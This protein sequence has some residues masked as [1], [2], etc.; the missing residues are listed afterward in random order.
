MKLKKNNKAYLKTTNNK[1][2][3]LYRFAQ[4]GI[5]CMGCVNRHRRGHYY[6]LTTEDKEH[7]KFPSWKL[8]SKNRKQWMKKPLKYSKNKYNWRSYVNISW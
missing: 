2:Y 8:V 7:R 4:L 3:K 5:C 6:I 1:A